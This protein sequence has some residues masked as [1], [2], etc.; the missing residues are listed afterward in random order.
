VLAD[1]PVFARFFDKVKDDPSW[2]TERIACGHF[3]MLELPAET[4]AIVLRAAV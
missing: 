3:P 1:G 4:A 2:R